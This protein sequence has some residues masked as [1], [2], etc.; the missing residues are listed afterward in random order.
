[1]D[2]LEFALEKERLTRE[3]YQQLAGKARNAGLRNI[4]EMLAEEEAIHCYVIESMISQ[5]PGLLTDTDVLGEAKDIFNGIRESVEK[6][7]F[8]VS[9]AEL[10]RD[11]RDKEQKSMEFYQQKAREV[12]DGIQ[13]EIFLKLAEEEQKHFIVF[14]NICEF[15]ASPECYLE[16]AEFVHT[17]EDF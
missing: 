15:V 17:A 8:S 7:D 3:S 5:K 9:E 4:L 11:A 10:Y 14:D 2:I 13:K 6:F 1:M 16:N 12:E